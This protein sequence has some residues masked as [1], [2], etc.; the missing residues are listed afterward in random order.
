MLK[1]VLHVQHDYY[2]LLTNDII[3]MGHC[4]NRSR[5]RFLKGSFSNDDGNGNENVM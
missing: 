4:R 3:V 5:R 1:C 2:A